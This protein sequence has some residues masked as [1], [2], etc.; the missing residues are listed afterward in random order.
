MGGH[1]RGLRARTRRL[2]LR[3]A[4][5]PWQER[6]RSEGLEAEGAEQ[7]PSCY[8]GIWWHGASQSRRQRTSFPTLPRWLGRPTGK[9]E[10]CRPDGQPDPGVRVQAPG[11][12]LAVVNVD[13]CLFPFF[14]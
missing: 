12:R 4:I 10:N 14:P 2:E 6:G 8:D 5:P 7:W 1:V 13:A 11:K 3:Q 9:L